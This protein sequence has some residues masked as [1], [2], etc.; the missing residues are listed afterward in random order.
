L[1]VR[2]YSAKLIDFLQ[3]K[4]CRQNGG[5]VKPEL[6]EISDLSPEACDE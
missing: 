1:S 6:E 3:T 5:K 2:Q 4:H